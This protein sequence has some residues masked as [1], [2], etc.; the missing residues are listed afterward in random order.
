MSKI[1]IVCLVGSVAVG[2][3]EK[4]R[5]LAKMGYECIDEQFYEDRQTA[6]DPQSV[7]PES[8]WMMTSFVRIKERCASYLVTG[9]DGNKS[10]IKVKN[11][12]FM[13][14]SPFDAAIF[15]EGTI[16][17][18]KMMVSF[19]K[20]MIKQFYEKGINIITVCIEDDKEKT[21][22]RVQDRLKM[23]GEEWRKVMK[24]DDRKVFDERWELF[25]EKK[26]RLGIE[27][28]QRVH[29]NTAEELLK[30]IK[31]KEEEEI[32]TGEIFDFS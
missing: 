16:K 8:S 21:W 27:W 5:G 14:R 17:D 6:F 1:D 15:A 2:K 28:D 24:E 11:P 10:Y 30:V 20:M 3:T 32:K 4:K 26:S 29:A 9:E 18:K 19:T 22:K 12:I 23:K 7:F 31:L 25:Y 13:D